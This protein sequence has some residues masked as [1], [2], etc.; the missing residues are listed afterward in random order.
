MFDS[1]LHRWSLIQDGEP[2]ITHSSL[3]LPVLWQ[4]GPAMLKVAADIDERYGALLMQW[5]DGDGAA[6]VF[7]REDDA[8]LLERAMGKRS[9]LAMAMN[10]EDD[11]ASRILCQ[12]AARLHAPREKLLPDPVPLTRWFRD[13]EPAAA[14]HGGTLADCSAIANA[15]LADPRDVAILHGDIHHGNILDF[16]S[17]G[18]L[19]IDPKRLHGERGFDFA[20]IFANEELPTITDPARFR[21][22]LAVVSAAAGL[23]P[24]RLLQ[25]ISAYSGLSAAWFL[26]DPNIEQA[27]KALTVARIAL[28]ELRT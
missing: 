10:G 5:W 7:A 26:G 9:L 13:L 8:V 17:R 4:D 11:E 28:A 27:E 1:Y 14:K 6:Y 22:Q 3:L 19:A 12:T 24:K 18:W 16:E 21:R 23:E 2:I 25:W 15:L 20:N